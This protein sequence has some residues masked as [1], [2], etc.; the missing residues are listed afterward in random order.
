MFYRPPSET[1]V[2]LEYICNMISI[3]E[4]YKLVQDLLSKNNGI[5]LS[6]KEYE[7]YATMA[8]NDMFD[9]LIGAKNNNMTAYGVNRTLDRRLKH[10]RV[11]TPPLAVTNGRVAQPDDLQLTRSV[12]YMFKGAPKALRP[13]DEDRF[14]FL[15]DD[16]LA[17]PVDEDPSYIEDNGSIRVFPTNIPTITIEY[18]KRPAVPKYAYT[19]VNRRPVFDPDNSVDFDWDKREENDLTMRILQYAAVSLQNGQMVQFTESKQ[20]NE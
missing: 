14:A 19:I 5:R 1:A 3:E 20:N 4:N 17:S 11:V 2:I 13:V 12:Y 16:P 7:R 9:K 6:P 8:S 10:L 15:F 18:L